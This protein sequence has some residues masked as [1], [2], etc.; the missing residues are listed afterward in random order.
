MKRCYSVRDYQQAVSLIRA[1]VPEVAI[2]TDIIAGF[3]GETDEEFRESYNFCQQ[4]QFARIHVFSYSP[5]LETDAARMPHQ[6][7]TEVKKERSQK[8]LALAEESTRNFRQQFLGRTMPVLFEK[9]SDGIWSGLTDNYIKVYI[10]SSQDLANQLLPVELVEVFNQDGVRGRDGTIA[11][12]ALHSLA[13][14]T[15]KEYNNSKW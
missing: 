3:P 15:N 13:N 5:R 6:V 7:S 9:R 8:M 10:Q 11:K 1:L 12:R 14:K 4:M 2:T